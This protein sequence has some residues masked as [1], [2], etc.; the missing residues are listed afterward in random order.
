M[1][2]RGER[3]CKDCG[4]TW[5]YADTGS[6]ECPSCGSPH[7]VG[8]DDR[9]L[10]T[11]KPVE[12]DLTAARNA[13]DDRSLREVA[14]ISR[15]DSRAYV[16][17]RGFISDG[18]L[19]PLSETYV[20]ALELAYAAAAIERS[21]S[22]SEDDPEGFYL[23]SLLRGADAG[24]RPPANEVPE[25][26]HHARGLAAAAAIRD[27]RKETIDWLDGVDEQDGEHGDVRR[28]LE[29]L[30]D[31]GKRVEAL[32]GE[33]APETADALVVAAREIGTALREGDEQS[34][35]S[36]RDR[37]ARLTAE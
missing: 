28:I 36:A 37:L 21:H 6:V 31:H 30:G 10:Q 17:A 16:R 19:R 33:V 15:D 7:S 22:V 20:A 8:V 12:F 27:Y 2:I 11:D 14:T 32:D 29:T 4:T 34:L 1:N 5:S 9:T 18:E 24:E 26:M 25:S 23:Y 3:R 35:A 13:V